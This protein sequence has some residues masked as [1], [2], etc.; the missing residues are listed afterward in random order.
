MGHAGAAHP[1]YDA[2][3]VGSGVSGSYVAYELCK[4]G[5]NCLL[6]EAGQNLNKHTYPRTEMDGNANLYWSGGIEFNKNASI[7]F[8]RPKV[9]GG[10]SIVNQALLDRFDDIAL[11][12]WREKSSINFL[13]RTELDPFYDLA[14]AEL[15]IEEIPEKYRNGNANIFK[16][17]FDKNE[18]KW[19]PLK[20]AQKDCKYDRGNDCIECLNGCR[21]D[22]KQSMPVTVLKKALSGELPGKLTIVSDFEVGTVSHG[23]S[24]KKIVGF[25]KN[26]DVE[27]FK[28]KIVVL[29]A[30]SMGNTKILTQSDFGKKLK[31]IGHHFYTHPQYMVLARYDK[32][33]NAHKG[34]L[35]SLKSDDL[36]FRQNGFKLENVFAGP[37]AI[38]M[39]LP[40][41]GDNH[42]KIM[43]DI[44]KLA[45]IEV[46]VRDT[47]PG[48]ISINRSGKIIVDKVLNGEDKLRRSKGLKA[49]ENIFNS[50]GA[51]EII[52]GQLPI[53]LHLMGG[54]G[55]GTDGKSSVFNP[56]FELHDQKGI[57]A[58]DSSIFPNAPGINPSLTIM[59][60]SIKCAEQITASM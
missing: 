27:T 29:G 42:S 13:N 16:E 1:I 7:G 45:C 43:N 25:Y 52:E 57:Y 2:I 60:L 46:A 17:G 4:K 49:I 47:N 51:V 19:A 5:L 21:L 54:C 58:A 59:A 34:P 18:Y 15:A 55:I 8:L 22:S 14:E 30:G 31:S 41:W 48:K 53:G 36:N 23:T 12:S 3:I 50:T 40:Q 38:S 44:T 20:R 56:E 28:A 9:V 11:D 32:K 6:L 39:L 37:V 26:G 24:D 35:Q 10:G 33:I